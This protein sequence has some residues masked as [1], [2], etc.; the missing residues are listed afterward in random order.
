MPEPV[1]LNE[2]SEY[3]S[4]APS[5]E[6][7][8]EEWKQQFPGEEN[9]DDEEEG[10]FD[11]DE[12][13]EEEEE[14][15]DDADEGEEDEEEDATASL[16]SNLALAYQSFHA[17]MPTEAI[18]KA[19]VKGSVELV[20]KLADLKISDDFQPAVMLVISNFLGDNGKLP[21]LPELLEQ[22]ETLIKG[23]DDDEEEEDDD[24][25][26]GADDDGEEEEEEEEEEVTAPPS[27]KRRT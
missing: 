5:T 25:D 4:S 18:V 8:F 3:L 10:D 11:D 9:G 21:T 22:L 13:E 12:E 24:D 2:V 1:S 17:K 7:A 15:D 6:E 16:V 20:Q 14:D 27:K 23:E 26:D 19:L